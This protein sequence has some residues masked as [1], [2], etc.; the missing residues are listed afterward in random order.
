M[1]I[2]S[3]F[4]AVGKFSTGEITEEERHGI[5]CAA[6]PGPGACGGMYTANTMASAMEAIGMSLPG[7][8]SHPRGGRR[9][10]R[11]S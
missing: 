5:E 1:D 10:R 11:R 3:A 4:E 2:V 7:N 8:A 6:C 9:A